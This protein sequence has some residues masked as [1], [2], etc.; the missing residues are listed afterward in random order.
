[1]LW[2]RHRLIRGLAIPVLIVGLGFLFWFPAPKPNIDAEV[3]AEGLGDSGSTSV[4]VSEGRGAS[5]EWISQEEA[6]IRVVASRDSVITLSTGQDSVEFTLHE[7]IVYTEQEWA[8]AEGH[9]SLRILGGKVVDWQPNLLE[10]GYIALYDNRFVVA[11]LVI[12]SLL[13]I[14][15]RTKIRYSHLAPF[16]IIFTLLTY[17]VLF[18][19]DLTPTLYWNTP[20]SDPY[21]KTCLVVQMCS[22]ILLVA[23]WFPVRKLIGRARPDLLDLMDNVVDK[24]GL[25]ILILV[26]L[27]QHLIGHGLF[28]YN[29]QPTDARYT[30][31]DWGRAMLQRGFLRF[32]S[33][34]LLRRMET[35]LLATLWALIYKLVPNG[36]IASALVPLFF[37][38]MVIICSFVLAKE[39]FGHRV[40][41]YAGLLLSVSPLFSFGSYF[42]GNDVPSAA[43]SALTLCLFIFALKRE[44][45][46]L[47]VVSGVCLALTTITK[48]TGI[49]CAFLVMVIYFAGTRRNKKILL[50]TLAFLMLLP[51]TYVTPYLLREGLVLNAL[52][53]GAEHL[54]TWAKRPMFQ[55]RDDEP[56]DWNDLILESGAVHYYMG[57][58]NTLF[59]FQYLVNGLGFPVFFWGIMILVQSV[60]A[61]FR[62]F[63]DEISSLCTDRSKLLSLSIWA[64]ALFLFLSPWSMR[65]TRFS[66]IAFPACAIL[67]GYGFALFKGETRFKGVTYGNLLLGLSVLMLL[68]Q[69]LSHYYNVVYLKNADYRDPIFIETSQPYYYIHHHHYGWHVGWNGA[70]TEHHFTGV[71]T[72]DGHFE[73]VKPFELE[74]YPDVLQVSEYNS[75]MTFDTWSLRGED[76]CDFVIEEGSWVTFDLQIDGARYPE[77]VHIYAGSIGIDKTVAATVPFT[78]QVD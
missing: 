37:S 1:M 41:F 30:Y 51:M 54:V 73:E 55:M 43:M 59:Y 9:I 22:S 28:G 65:S 12:F 18:F 42:L 74:S 45:I 67:A 60:E 64:L 11:I 75:M 14:Y 76:G 61:W 38:E 31:M 50:I 3:Q 49:Y 19:L 5:L 57:P 2:N 44:S 35:P 66:Y 52:E 72:T 62:G 17:Q 63:S 20:L 24:Y 39:F 34:G 58:S 47:G 69:S 29:L 56:A 8:T 71:I 4:T 7:L 10:E 25:I 53:A 21:V 40:G 16:L 33:G 13:Y 68:T 27:L 77:R 78:M 32:W 36:Y 26:P 46:L 15:L 23:L 6:I 70:D 48:L